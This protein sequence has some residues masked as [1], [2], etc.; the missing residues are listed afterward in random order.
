MQA[1]QT[2]GLNSRRDR[3]ERQARSRTMN[4]AAGSLF[5]LRVI[6]SQWACLSVAIY[7]SIVL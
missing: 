5:P 4:D 1:G 7:F 3:F 2:F 6:N